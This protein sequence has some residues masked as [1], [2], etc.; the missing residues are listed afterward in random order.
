MRLVVRVFAVYL[1]FVSAGCS[2]H[3]P[4]GGKVTFSDNG[5]PLT[6]GEVTVETESFTAR[7]ALDADGN[8]T[9]GSLEDADGLPP[10]EYMVS[11]AGAVVGWPPVPLI[12]RKYFR[13]A[14]SGLVV[15]AASG[16]KRF[17]FMVDRYVPEEEVD[18]NETDAETEPLE[19]HHH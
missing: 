5:S 10:G 14:T 8:Y 12:D 18:H 9:I 17:D 2:N 19:L 15:V 7:G 4:L 1:L 13:G 11:I 3:V 16:N 6:V